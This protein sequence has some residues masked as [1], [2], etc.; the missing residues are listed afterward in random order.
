MNKYYSIPIIIFNVYALSLLLISLSELSANVI[1]SIDKP[2]FN[3]D[4]CPNLSI[5]M[6]F[7]CVLGIITS[8][9]TFFTPILIEVYNRKNDGNEN[10]NCTINPMITVTFINAILIIADTLY[11][12]SLSSVYAEMSDKC[13]QYWMNYDDYT[14]K[15]FKC[16]IYSVI[17]LIIFV[18]VGGFLLIIIKFII[19]VL[20]NR[21]NMLP[22]SQV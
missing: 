14:L 1:N 12:L 18:V 4:E 21:Q 3:F 13:V 22:K 15:M 20:N 19:V 6:W 7:A 17:V 10:K 9:G 5:H 11:R 16:T 2:D 8:I